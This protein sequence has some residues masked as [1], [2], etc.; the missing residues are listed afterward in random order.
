[1]LP[2]RADVRAPIQSAWHPWNPERSWEAGAP[3]SLLP[4][5]LPAG[6]VLR[7][8][9]G[10][11]P[12]QRPSSPSPPL[13]SWL[14]STPGLP[15]VCGGEWAG[16][17]AHVGRRRKRSCL[18]ICTTHMTYHVVSDS[19]FCIT[20]GTA[21]VLGRD[22]RLPS[23]DVCP[24]P[25]VCL[26]CREGKGDSGRGCRSLRPSPCSASLPPSAWSCS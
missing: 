17:A 2:P 9:L 7:R 1:M 4:C 14:R 22:G 19:D 13:Y 10:P 26:G 8:L 15:P 21:S 16:P 23:P 20:L 5:I 12:Q 24:P 6:P 11:S 18:T 25:A 3:S